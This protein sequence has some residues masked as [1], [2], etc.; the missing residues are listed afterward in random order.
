MIRAGVV[1]ATGYAGAE[2]VRLIMGHPHMELARVTSGKEAGRRLD[3]VYPGF[4]GTCDATL[5][6]PDVADLASA[7][8]V[9]FLA[10]PHTASLAMT[11]Q[12]V[13]AGVSVVDLSADYRLA[14][15]AVFESWYGTP[16]T[17]P[18]L[19]A[20][21]VYGI[22]EL[23][24]DEVAA[25]HELPA[26]EPRI[27][28]NPGCYPTAATLAAAPLLRA[29]L[30]ACGAPV[31]VDAISGVTGA[32]KSCTARTHFCTVDESVQAYGVGHHRHLPEIAQ[33]LTR[34]A[35]FDVNV[36]FTPH[37]APYKRGI[38]ATVYLPLSRE[39]SAAELQDLYERVYA[40]ERFVSVLPAGAQPA[41]ASVAGSERAQV[42][43]VLDER[44]HMAIATCAIDN[45]VRGAAGQA[46]Q[47]ANLLCG[48]PEESGLTA[49]VP[50][51]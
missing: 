17:S 32:G 3:D 49:P 5:V 42:A 51:I 14:D 13:A 37:L 12:L 45:L 26:G 44:A 15:A 2:L 39:V 34:L 35:G 48:L 1:G 25:L 38:L 7:C 11:P 33:N 22:P 31:I 50:L 18:E 9:V 8:D 24:R 10:V 23:N 36:V 47:N 40:D 46:V 27:V 20:R 4:I 29:D 41:T 30:L 16:H 6:E 19:L 43:V 21:A 28:A